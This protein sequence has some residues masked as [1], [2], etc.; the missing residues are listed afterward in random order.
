MV[1]HEMPSVVILNAKMN[2]MEKHY[3]KEQ[4]IISH[5]AYY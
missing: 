4:Y 2:D 3:S 1:C 5:V